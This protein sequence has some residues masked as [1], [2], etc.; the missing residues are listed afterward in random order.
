M[1]SNISPSVFEPMSLSLKKGDNVLMD[2]Y[3][4]IS[5]L[6]SFSKILERI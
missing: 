4:A 1:L 3:R 2:N 5:V 6:S